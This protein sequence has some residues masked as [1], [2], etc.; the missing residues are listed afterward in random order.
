M[1][2][3]GLVPFEGEED[4]GD[5]RS[6]S[7]ESRRGLELVP[8]EGEDE[9]G[10]A[11][12]AAPEPSLGV[13]P[14]WVEDLLKLYAGEAEAASLNNAGEAGAIGQ[15]L[16]TA[17]ADLTQPSRERDGM[18]PEYVGERG[19]N[20]QEI[21]DRSMAST[22]GKVGYGAGIVAPMIASG[23]AAAAPVAT[24]AGVGAVQ[25]ALAAGGEHGYDPQTVATGG[26]AGGALAGLGGLL[27][28]RAG[29]P[30]P[31]QLFGSRADQAMRFLAEEGKRLGSQAFAGAGLG[32]LISNRDPRDMAMGALKGAAGAVALRAGSAALPSAAP[33]VPGALGAMG[34]AAAP[35]GGALAGGAAAPAKAQAQEKAYGTAPTMAWAVQ[36][37]L[38]GGNTGL[39][40]M[41]EQRLTEAILSGDEDRV[42]SANFTLQQKSPAY[43]ARL[44]RELES[45]QEE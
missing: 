15:R 3:L 17:L 22:P 24:R 31:G 14:A 1:P 10:A 43:A 39:A 34:T 25:G 30:A 29:S 35:I 28:Q 16:G 27:A 38:A 11:A 4:E 23:G 6:P 19:V 8:F 42:I 20:P 7:A 26:L 33:Y 45:L 32:A 41:D 40:P 9:D 2:G 36:S 18:A 37:V 44:Q 12:P 13:G 21:L 5:E